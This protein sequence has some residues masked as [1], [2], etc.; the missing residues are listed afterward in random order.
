MKGN[1]LAK[2]CVKLRPF[3]VLSD[4]FVVLVNIKH[5]LDE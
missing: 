4:K 5:N 3:V 2:N 1:I